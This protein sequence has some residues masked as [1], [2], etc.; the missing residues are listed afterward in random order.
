M[1]RAQTSLKARVSYAFNFNSQSHNLPHKLFIEKF[2]IERSKDQVCE[3][4]KQ[5]EFALEE[6]VSLITLFWPI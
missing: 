4:S 2:L 6:V 3:D 1:K 5:Q